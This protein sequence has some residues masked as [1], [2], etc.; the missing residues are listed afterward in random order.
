MPNPNGSTWRWRKLRARVLA[1]EPNCWCGAAADTVDH[2]TPLSLGGA[3]YDRSNLRG[4]CARH[5]YS[6]GN[7][8]RGR[9]PLGTSRD[10][11]SSE[12][13]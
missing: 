11:F 4:M 7:G 8:T 5:N 9:R 3:R 2:I 13:W 10:W 6:R 12:Q 1:E